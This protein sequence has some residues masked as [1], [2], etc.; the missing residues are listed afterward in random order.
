MDILHLI[1]RLEEELSQGHRLPLTSIVVV[2]EQRLWDTIDAMRISIPEEVQRAQRVERERE[3]I[4]AQA[5]EEA[6]RIVELA[7]KRAEEMTSSHE[8]IQSAQAQAA[9]IVARAQSE[10]ERLQLEADSYALEVLAQLEEQLRRKL[11]TVQ[12]GVKLLSGK[13]E[14]AT[15][16][17]DEA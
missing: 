17:D 14:T 4:L 5:R 7:R 2:N 12:N 8:L 15:N 16:P 1:D 11:Q 13:K 6:G 3:R 9:E 10:A